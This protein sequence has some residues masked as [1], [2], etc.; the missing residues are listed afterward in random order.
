MGLLYES[1]I[2]LFICDFSQWMEAK[3]MPQ[4]GYPANNRLISGYGG[5]YDGRQEKR[6]TV[7]GI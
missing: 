5:K 4:G 6:K 2:D 3:W 7:N 1:H